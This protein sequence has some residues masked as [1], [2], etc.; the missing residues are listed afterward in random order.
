MRTD[1]SNTC[2]CIVIVKS[3]RNHVDFVPPRPEPSTTSAAELPNADLDVDLEL[4]ER[5]QEFVRARREH[6]PYDPS[7]EEA[8][9][10]FH[11]T[12]DPLIRR[13]ASA[14]HVSSYDLMDCVQEVWAKVIQGLLHLHF[15]PVRGR[16]RGWLF[17]LTSHV[18]CDLERKW[19]AHV[20]VQ[21]NARREDDLLSPDDPVSACE[22]VWIMEEVRELLSI[23]QTHLSP[24]RYQVLYL[25]WIEGFSVD[26]IARS[27]AITRQQVYS[28]HTRAWRKLRILF[29][30]ERFTARAV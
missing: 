22:R 2:H 23:M 4:L 17:T 14:Y 27:L 30:Q 10:E 21:L 26:E 7:L 20:L 28:D 16:F 6:R 12:F 5:V 24:R 15:D 29:G 3:P 13:V 18:L 19:N 25:R 8:W 1:G 9:A 11:E